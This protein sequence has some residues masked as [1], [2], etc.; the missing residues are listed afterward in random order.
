VVR[1]EEI[2]YLEDPQDQPHRMAHTQARLD[3][4]RVIVTG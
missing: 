2:A 1:A 4:L 3:A